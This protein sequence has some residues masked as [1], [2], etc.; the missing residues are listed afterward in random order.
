VTNSYGHNGE[1][2]DPGEQTADDQAFLAGAAQGVTVLFSSGDN[3]DLAALNG[4][5]SGAWPA[6]SAY[7]TGVGGTS[8][9]ITNSSTGAKA[10]YGWGTYR[11]LLADAQ[12]A[13]ATS[14]IDS[15]VETASAYGLTFD[16]YVFYGGSVGGISL[17]EAQPSYQA[18]AVPYYLATELNLASGYVET[19]PNAQ[20][21][22]P[23]I[24]MDADPYTGYLYG[25][26]FTIAGNAIADHGCK[27]I[28][29]T[30]EYCET[31]EGGTSLASP[32]MA[33]VFA[34]MDQAREASGEPEVGFANPLLYSIGSRGN[35]TVFD[36]EALN[37]II[38]PT[39]PVA[40]L[41][42]YSTNLEEVRVVTINSVPELIVTTPYPFEVCG[43][44]LCLGI[45]DEWN[46]TSLSPVFDPPTPAG[47][48]DVTGLG[49]PWVPKLI[50]EE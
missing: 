50:K 31:G 29:S 7:V 18:T 2:I 13:S 4:V 25:E 35:G 12:V 47:Y 44:P 40:V 49:V 43:L 9:L 11:A 33:G 27:A 17:L 37:Q 22:S 26:T 39:E 15:G 14:V 1:A 24:A 5:A 34:I 10:E 42:G 3:G 45:D 48:N 36:T 21:V 23:D 8:L 28:S 41:R 30:E 16:A 46:F 6:T 19:L 32:L 38:A 20:R